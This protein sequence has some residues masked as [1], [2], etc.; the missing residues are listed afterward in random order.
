[1]CENKLK[2]AITERNTEL[3]VSLLKD[4]HILRSD[5][6]TKIHKGNSFL[7]VAVSRCEGDDVTVLQAIIKH[8]CVA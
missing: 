6:S 8:R 4:Q 1:M 7:H 3:A 2:K 5:L